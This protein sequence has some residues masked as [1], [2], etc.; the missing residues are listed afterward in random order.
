MQLQKVFRKPE[1]GAS[2]L[3]K[4]PDLAR[5]TTGCA[6]LYIHVLQQL[7]A[8]FISGLRESESI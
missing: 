5:S 4:L 3:A 2:P 7:S 6:E 8:A 1:V